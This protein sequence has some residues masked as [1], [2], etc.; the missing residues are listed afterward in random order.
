M[1]ITTQLNIRIGPQA[2]SRH[3]S[4]PPGARQPFE[5][6]KWPHLAGPDSLV[7]STALLNYMALS[8]PKGQGG[9]LAFAIR[10]D[11]IDAISAKSSSQEFAV[12]LESL[13]MAAAGYFGAEGTV[14][15]YSNNATLLIA[16]DKPILLAQNDIENDVERRLRRIIFRHGAMDGTGI[17]LSVGGPVQ[18]QGRSADRAK[19]VAD[20]VMTLAENREINKRGKSVAGLF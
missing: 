19:T 12:L 4:G 20:H 2:P 1:P 8:P 16:S 9:V 5:P 14:M 3:S 18:P 15:A 10:I 13:A 11:E 17:T 7:G 6:S